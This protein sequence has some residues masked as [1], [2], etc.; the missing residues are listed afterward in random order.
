MRI[1]LGL[2]NAVALVLL[3]TGA[4]CQKRDPTRPPLELPV[5]QFKP[6]A[7]EL[8]LDC[9]IATGPLSAVV[10]VARLRRESLEECNRRWA[11][12]RA[13]QPLED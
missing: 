5:Q 8:L 11:K 6:L 4:T 10:D 7:P 9:P 12:V 1:A 13:L 3:L 2:L